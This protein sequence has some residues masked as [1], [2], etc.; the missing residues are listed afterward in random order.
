MITLKVE[1]WKDNAPYG[2]SLYHA[3]IGEDGDPCPQEIKA[4]S[5]EGLGILVGE[6]LELRIVEGMD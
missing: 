6:E 3:T 2:N 1:I 4:D 5:K